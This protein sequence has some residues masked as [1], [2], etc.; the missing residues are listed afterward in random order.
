MNAKVAPT[1]REYTI[2]QTPKAK[3]LEMHLAAAERDLAAQI[4]RA[5]DLAKSAG[6][7]LNLTFSPQGR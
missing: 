7:E 1:K 5:F 3:T 2:R 6:Q 4:R